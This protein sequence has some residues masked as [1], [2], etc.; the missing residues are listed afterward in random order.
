MG[1]SAATAAVVVAVFLFL[2]FFG[3]HTCEVIP[4]TV[5][6]SSSY[7][8]L[9]LLLRICFPDQKSFSNDLRR[10]LDATW[11]RRWKRTPM[12]SCIPLFPSRSTYILASDSLNLL[13]SAAQSRVSLDVRK[14]K[15]AQSVLFSIRIS[16]NMVR[17]F[18]NVSARIIISRRIGDESQN[19]EI[20]A[21]RRR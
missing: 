8:R 15:R 1:S 3:A 6:P 19:I 5:T 4:L 9:L 14:I 13:S 10:S 18:C 17:G 16:T 20:Y 11:T 2:L 21:F 12:T 7:R